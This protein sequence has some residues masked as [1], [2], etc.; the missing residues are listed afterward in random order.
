M[1][2]GF[3]WVSSKYHFFVFSQKIQDRSSFLYNS[4]KLLLAVME[5]FKCDCKNYRSQ[6][7][8]YLSKLMAQAEISGVCEV[9]SASISFTTIVLL[10]KK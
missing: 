10:Q 4:V 1:L 2:W 9:F 5:E 8:F 3:Y 7:F 6:D